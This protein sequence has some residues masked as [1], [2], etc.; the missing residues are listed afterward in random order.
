MKDKIQ[1]D[2]NQAL[3]D[4][5]EITVSTLRLLLSEIHNR[6]IA[7]RGAQGKNLNNEEVVK[8]IRQQIK[9]R[10]EAIEAYQ[11]GGRNDLVEKEK[12][13][14]SILNKYLPQQLTP[15][16]LEVTI[17]SAVEE[18]GAKSMADFGKV[19]GAVM[20]KV[21]GRAEGKAV[22]EAVKKVLSA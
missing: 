3:K 16:K 15:K 5:D 13:E 20:A 1:K 8:T 19:M 2:L 6:E 22:S 7:L 9:Q 21:K 11:K 17:Q 10:E 4:K 12:R 18:V 14:L